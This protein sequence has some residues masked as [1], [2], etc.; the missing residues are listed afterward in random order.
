MKPSRHKTFKREAA[1]VVLL[2]WLLLSI[3]L[4]L[5]GLTAAEVELVT[6]LALPVL[7]FVAAALGMEW[8]GTQSKWSKVHDKPLALD[9]EQDETAGGRA[10]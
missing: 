2:W 7:M 3:A 6:G 9:D 8:H 4:I 5:D 1:L 10:G